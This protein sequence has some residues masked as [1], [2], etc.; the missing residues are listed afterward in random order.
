VERTEETATIKKE[1][2]RDKRLQKNYRWSLERRNRLA[3]AQD[4][5]CALCG[6]PENP[7][8]PLNCDHEHF[9][10]YISP[11]L[12][13]PKEYKWSARAVFKDG[14]WVECVGPTQAKA[15]AAVKDIALPRSVRGLLCPGRRG[16][17]RRLGW[18]DDIEFLEKA[19]A[20]L[21]NPPARKIS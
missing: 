10:I 2:D 4:R 11:N 12:G 3:D 13:A 20:Y 18:V 1:R 15:R 21:K 17:N 14:S 8:H 19:L 7:E 9:K 5:K 16:C 6:R